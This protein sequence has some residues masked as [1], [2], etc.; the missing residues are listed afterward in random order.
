MGV[1]AELQ[2]LK[3]ICETGFEKTDGILQRTIQQVAVLSEKVDS[4]E[5]RFQKFDNTDHAARLAVLEDRAAFLLKMSW[6]MITGVIAAL[7]IAVATMV[8]SRLERAEQH[9][10]HQGTTTSRQ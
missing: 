3:R 9:Q 8:W 6:W 2:Q 1:E 5:D 4:L 7:L 10:V